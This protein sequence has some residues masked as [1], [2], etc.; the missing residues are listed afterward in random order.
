VTLNLSHQA[1][2]G[3]NFQ[4]KI[5]FV[6]VCIIIASILVDT[7]I[8][9]TSVYTGGLHGSTA[10]IL[11]F[12]II[13]LI[14]AI[15]QYVILKV[16]TIKEHFRTR[17]M[18]IV[19]KSAVI[20]QYVLIAILLIT[21]LQM[22]LTSSY[23]SII[24]KIVTWIN[25]SMSIVFLGILS[26]KFISWYSTRRNGILI[27]YAIA[28]IF[29]CMYGIVSIIDI[30]YGLTHGGLTKVGIT[31]SS[32]ASIESLSFISSI[33]NSAYFIISLLAFISTWFATV[34][35]LK[36]Y[37]NKIGKAKYW[38]LVSIPLAY[39]LTQ[40][41]TILLYLFTPIRL[42]DPIIFGITYTLVFSASKPIGGI[43]FGISFWI[44]SRGLSNPQVKKYMIIS[45]YGLL[46]LFT[47]SQHQIL[48]L[49]PYPPFGLP[50]ICYV[51]LASYLILIGVYS[52][53]LSVA[54]D[55]VLRM[56]FYRSAMSQMSLLK[57]IGVSE[58]EKQL[59]ERYKSVDKRARSLEK[60]D[61]FEKDNVKEVLHG[62]VDEMDKENAREILHDVLTELYSK[63]RP[64]SEL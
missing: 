11:L 15:G 8:V 56:E 24:L 34:L 27:A 23:S 55:K 26:K 48:L 21:I 5:I 29:L 50:T 46:L 2:L 60:D 39:F 10:D 33:V 1:A 30:S 58:M 37:S 45:G 35:L 3:T 36:H 18:I 6:A 47:A 52:S 57:T 64:K 62:L 12:T 16:T 49:N 31:K 53:A 32:V 7:T 14:Y 51:G 42:T 17:D 9:K 41:Q 22:I 13:T 28:M 44:V 43:L 20:L 63:S 54:R 4:T 19:H 40:F 25:Y 59:M 38:I 61:R